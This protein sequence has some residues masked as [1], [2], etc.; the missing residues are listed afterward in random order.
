MRTFLTIFQA[1]LRH[2]AYERNLH[3]RRTN[4]AILVPRAV[5][6][7][8]NGDDADDRIRHRNKRRLQR[9]VVCKSTTPQSSVPPIAHCAAQHLAVQRANLSGSALLTKYCFLLSPRTEFSRSGGFCFLKT[10][11]TAKKE[12]S[13]TSFSGVKFLNAQPHTTRYPTP[14]KVRIRTPG[15]SFKY[16]RR[17]VI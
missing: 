14:F 11:V 10:L 16:S 7:G 12:S 4:G 8:C 6:R 13:K 2:F 15:S 1:K 5:S 3:I 17:R 9:P